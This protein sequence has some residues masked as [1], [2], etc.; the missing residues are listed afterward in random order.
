MQAEFDPLKLDN[1]LCFPLYAASRQIIKRYTPFL[2]ALDLTYTQYVAMMVLWECG[3]ISARDLGRRLYLDSGTLTP[4]LK[5]LERKGCVTRR[6]DPDDDRV[7]RV[8]LTDAGRA[9]REKALAVPGQIAACIP[10]Q[11]EKAAQLHALL[12]ELLAE[13]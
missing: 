5:S 9:L 6:R 13:V 3:E 1:Q 4:V 11:P 2:A 12:R 8:A 7:L 10:M